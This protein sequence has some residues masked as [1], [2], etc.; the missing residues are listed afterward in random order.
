[1]VARPSLYVYTDFV[2]ERESKLFERGKL[3]FLGEKLQLIPFP[4]SLTKKL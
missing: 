1:M 2:V 4:S 3:K